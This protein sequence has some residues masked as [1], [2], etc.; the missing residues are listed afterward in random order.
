MRPFSILVSSV[1]TSLT[2]FAVTVGGCAGGSDTDE[3][4]PTST[5]T[6][7]TSSTA[8]NG[9]GGNMGTGGSGADGGSGGQ[10]PDPCTGSAGHLLISEVG[11]APAGFE[12]IE[13]WNPGTSAVDLTNYYLSDNSTYYGIAS[14]TAWAPI[15]DHPAT[16]YLARFPSGTSLGPSDVLVLQAGNGD[17]DPQ[18]SMC[19]DFV[20]ANAQAP[21]GAGQVPP[22][23]EPANGRLPATADLGALVS[24]SREML[25]LFC[26]GGSTTLPVHDVD[27]VTW[28]A[29]FEDGT[30]VD[31]TA[32]AGYAPDTAPGSQNAAPAPAEAAPEAMQSIARCDG[33]ETGE[34]TAG[35]NGISG[36]DETSEQLSTS[37]VIECD[38]SPGTTGCVT[39]GPTCP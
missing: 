28:G 20:L 5:T 38:P 17:F 9:G 31:K 7:G 12:F 13:I 16:D 11:T 29:T 36:H 35:G 14:G 10:V 24:N 1:V 33:T 4:T 22:M 34:T 6:T 39:P 27:Y 32:A 19:P 25:V 2:V 26:W 18:F 37:F 30:R 15:T 3:T 21:C 8:G 23:T